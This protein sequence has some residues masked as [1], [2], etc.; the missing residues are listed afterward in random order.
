MLKEATNLNSE[1]IEIPL[2]LEEA[3]EESKEIT[4]IHV[5]Q[6]NIIIDCFKL[7]EETHLSGIIRLHEHIGNETA[8]QLN[9]NLSLLAATTK[10]CKISTITM[11]DIIEEEYVPHQETLLHND[12]TVIHLL[13]KPFQILTLKIAFL[14]E[15]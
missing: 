10:K 8:C 11:C 7:D 1:L 15:E 13:F 4:F 9:L 6:P 3:L 12:E 2:I 5:D 14:Y